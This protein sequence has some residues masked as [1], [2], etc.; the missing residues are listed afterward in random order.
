M[1]DFPL[2]GN[3]TCNFFLMIFEGKFISSC[4][5]ICIDA[6]LTKEKKRG[7]GGKKK[8]KKKK[9]YKFKREM[10]FKIKSI[11]MKV[12]SPTSNSNQI[13]NACRQFN[14]CF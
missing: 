9:A 10:N 11:M 6:Y 7:G 8:E 5:L 12:F 14:K 2:I 4:A 1:M 3:K 13:S